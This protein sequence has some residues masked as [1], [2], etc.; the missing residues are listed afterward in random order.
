[1]RRA[2]ERRV[3]PRIIG[4]RCGV[5]MRLTGDLLAAAS[6]WTI[7]GWMPVSLD[8]VGLEVVRRLGEKKS[9]LLLAPR[10]ETPGF[11]VG[12]EMRGVDDSRLEEGQEAQLH[13]GRI[14]AGFADDSGLPDRGTVDL[15]EPVDRFLEEVGAG[16]RHAVPLS[17]TRCDPSTGNR[18]RDR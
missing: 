9:H 10:A 4:T 15:G 5:K 8:A 12:D 3:Y 7:S 2:I 18:R 16:V 17:R 11:A 14:A 13:G 6:P 1:V